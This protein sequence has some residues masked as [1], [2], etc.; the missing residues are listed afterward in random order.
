[1]MKEKYLLHQIIDIVR[2]LWQKNGR[3]IGRHGFVS[4]R[5]KV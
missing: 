2:L 1:M 3:D 4:A 5:L